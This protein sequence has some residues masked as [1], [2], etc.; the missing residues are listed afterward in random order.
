L[1]VVKH[2]PQRTCVGCGQRDDPGRMTR[3]AID[4]RGLL[5][6]VRNPVTGRTAYLHSA[7][8]CWKGLVGRRSI[9]RSL[10]AS[11]AKEQKIRLLQ[12]LDATERDGAGEESIS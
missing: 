9:D 5:V 8:E 2:R 7:A 3:F 12:D 1:T 6:L 10:R 11:I 4:G